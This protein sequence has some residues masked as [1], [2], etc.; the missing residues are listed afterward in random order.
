MVDKLQLT[1]APDY[2]QTVQIVVDNGPQRYQ[3]WGKTMKNVVNTFLCVTQ[4]GFCCVYFVFISE[5]IKQVNH[6][7]IIIFSTF[8]ISLI[9]FF[10]TGIRLLWLRVGRAF[11]HGN[12]TVA[13]TFDRADQKPEIPGAFL[14]V[15]QYFNVYWHYHVSVLQLSRPTQRPGEELCLHLVADPSIFWHCFVRFRRNRFG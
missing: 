10:V 7:T 4:L 8:D 5:N 12:N 15:R 9:N 13:N 2:A 14:D 11:S 6:I 1:E 3:G